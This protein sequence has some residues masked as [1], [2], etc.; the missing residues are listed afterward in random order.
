MQKWY[1]LIFAF[2]LSLNAYHEAFGLTASIKEKYPNVLLTD[3]YGILNENDLASHT[4]EI[5][6]PPFLVAVKNGLT[7]NYW[8]CFPRERISVIIEDFGLDGDCTE[9]VINVRSDEAEHEYYMR[10]S[11]DISNAKEFFNYWRKLAKNEKYVCLAGGFSH[12]RE[13]ID[14]NKKLKKYYWIFEKFKTKKGCD[15]YFAGRCNFTYKQF[16]QEQNSTYHPKREKG[17]SAKSSLRLLSM[18]Y[19]NHL[20]FYTYYWRSIYQ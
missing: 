3:D 5:K 15:S 7:R 10:R 12:E 14:D 13:I 1:I 19:K 8:Q 11:T 6:P 2:I 4:W 17:K 9:V 18:I 20:V 16:L